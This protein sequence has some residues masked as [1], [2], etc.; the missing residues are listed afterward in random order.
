MSMT[1]QALVDTACLLARADGNKSGVIAELLVP[2]VATWVAQ[3]AAVDPARR[4]LVT[5]KFV[6]ALVNGVGPMPA[7]ALA[8]YMKFAA[9]ND[10]ADPTMARKMRW[11]AHWPEFIRPLDLTL[12]YFTVTDNGT[13][14]VMTRPGVAYSP[15][16][17][18]T[19]NIELSIPAR[20]AI[21]GGNITSAP[22]ID[23]EMILALT[24]ALKGNWEAVI[25]AEGPPK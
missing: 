2:R 7:D 15:V 9:V 18:M 19:G 23:Q 13:G 24:A 17:G 5:T 22:E 20:P 25:T 1:V 16:A 8:E 21:A 11:I 6:I 3:R 12:G 14:F 10:P 4:G